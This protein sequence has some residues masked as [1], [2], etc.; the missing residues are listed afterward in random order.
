MNK[1]TLIF[2]LGMVCI[3]SILMAQPGH[4]GPKGQE[5]P[6]GEA[7]EAVKA[8]IT[9]NVLPVITAQREKL[10]AQLSPA[11]QAKVVEIREALEAL[12][13][14]RKELRKSLKKLRE[15]Y[16]GDGRPELPEELSESMKEQQ[17]AHR[18]LMTQAWEIADA[19]EDDIEALLEEMKD[20]TE[21]WK[22]E[23][24]GILAQYRPDKAEWKGENEERPHPERPGMGRPGR[25]KRGVPGRLMG[26][27]RFQEPVRFLLFDGTLPGE[28][29]DIDQDLNVFP[30][31][32]QQTNTLT[33][34]IDREGPVT[35]KL[36]ND[37]GIT[38]QN[39]LSE[40]QPLG[41]YD[42][43]V[44]ISDLKSGVYI[45][46]I[47]TAKGVKTQKLVVE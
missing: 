14:E 18:Q 15:E 29:A 38:V 13:A 11:E 5:G 20:D 9:G 35:I 27:L 33:Y 34:S 3:S 4:S 36:I 21:V 19:H 25:G 12:K 39:I 8:Y 42:V 46:R 40:T 30:N 41:I 26:I 6:R 17:K 24:H 44:D 32:A 7:A 43:K 47:E 28:E 16:D 2:A 31:P 37:Q 45:Y 22:E 23:I 10:N 1:R